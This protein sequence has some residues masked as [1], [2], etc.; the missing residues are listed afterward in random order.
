MQ[1]KIARLNLIFGS[2][3]SSSTLPITRM[4]ITNFVE[5]DNIKVSMNKLL[6][7]ALV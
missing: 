7:K 6:I 1:E 2:A 4:N 3:E 5:E